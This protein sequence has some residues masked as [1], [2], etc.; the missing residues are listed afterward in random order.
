MDDLKPC[1][2][3]GGE[4]DYNEG[5]TGDDT[6]WNYYACSVCEAMQPYVSSAE[7]SAH[8]TS[9]NQALDAEAW[10]TRVDSPEIT[11]LRE[12]VKVLEEA[13]KR[14]AVAGDHWSQPA[15]SDDGMRYAHESTAR[16]ARA[17]LKGAEE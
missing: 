13:L 7:Q 5:K 9:F 3:C 17:A 2:F 4:A 16:L 10:N 12:R 11:A 6:P 15:L 8:D 14:I 1:P